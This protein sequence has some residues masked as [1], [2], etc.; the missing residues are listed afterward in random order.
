M[1]DHVRPKVTDIIIALVVLEGEFTNGLFEAY[2]MGAV[3]SVPHDAS[4]KELADSVAY[5]EEAVTKEIS[6]EDVPDATSDCLGRY[7][8]VDPYG[9][10]IKSY[11]MCRYITCSDSSLHR[12]GCLE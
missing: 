11:V 6:E 5:V 10:G 4:D 1:F 9:A 12:K 8:V 3:C 2:P 7:A